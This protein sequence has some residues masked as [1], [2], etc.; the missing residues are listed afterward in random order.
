MNKTSTPLAASTLEIQNFLHKYPDWKIN[1]EQESLERIFSL[2]SYFKGLCFLQ[3]LGWLAQKNN[4]HPDLELS[5][6]Q[7]KCRLTTH[8][9]GNKVSNMDLVF[10]EMIEQSWF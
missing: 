8:D 10:A 5:F 2:K 3:T 6:T 9:I 1:G 4:H 7:L